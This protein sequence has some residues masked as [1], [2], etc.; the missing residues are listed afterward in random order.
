MVCPSCDAVNRVPRAKLGAGANCGK[1]R[2]AL[3]QAAPLALD[4]VRFERHLTR[5]E[6]PLLVD[7]WAPWCG[8][9]QMMAPAFEAAARRLEPTVRLLKVNTEEAQGLAQRLAIRSIPTLVFFK[10]GAEV[11]RVSGA[12]NPTQLEAWARQQL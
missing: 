5:S 10:A 7:F 3:F 4:E 2:R 6:L 8:P 11:A 1:C 12:M 9:C